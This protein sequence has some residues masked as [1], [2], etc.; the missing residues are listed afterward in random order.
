[1]FRS[2]CF[3]RSLVFAV[4]AFMFASTARADVQVSLRN[5]RVTL[6]AKDATLRQ[7]LAEWA[8]VGKL[9]VIN[10]ERIPGGPLTL[11]LRDVPEGEALDIL[12]R[13]LSGYIAAPRATVV[14]D[15]SVYDSISVMPTVAAAP[16]R[17]VAGV[18]PPAP[19]TPPGAFVPNDDDQSGPQGARPP[20]FAPQFPGQPTVQPGT[21][22]NV[23][24]PVLPVVRPGIVPPQPNVNPNDPGSPPIPAPP[25]QNAPSATPGTQGPGAIGVSAPGMVAPAPAASQPGQVPQPQRPPGD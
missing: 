10:L 18:P 9:R 19:F 1:V 17:S 12:L 20:V 5:G 16:T 11:E 3:T 23:A 14:A 2:L 21:P 22:N 4:C 8:R 25:F 7:I 15:A 6:I 24:R 13:S